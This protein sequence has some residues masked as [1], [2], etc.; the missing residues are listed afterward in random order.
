[1]NKFIKL[2]SGIVINSEKIEYFLGEYNKRTESQE[3]VVFH[4]LSPIHSKE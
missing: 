2:P 1:M 3:A 4:I